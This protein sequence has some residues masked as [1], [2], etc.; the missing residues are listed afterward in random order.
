M[1]TRR[2][3]KGRTAFRAVNRAH[4][5]FFR[6]LANLSWAVP[7]PGTEFQ[8]VSD[9]STRPIYTGRRQDVHRQHAVLGHS[10]MDTAP[11]VRGS[12]RDLER[13]RQA[14]DERCAHAH[15]YICRYSTVWGSSS[16]RMRSSRHAGAHKPCD[17]LSSSSSSST[18]D[19]RRGA[20]APRSSKPRPSSSSA[21]PYGVYF[22]PLAIC[23]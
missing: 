12:E 19:A 1:G 13:A 4:R 17:R 18:A 6:F 23:I 22:F 2:V 5:I 11:N 3:D 14:S 20:L 8:S 9:T 15:T 7:H 10:H 16:R 21:W